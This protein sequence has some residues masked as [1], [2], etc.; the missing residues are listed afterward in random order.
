M[1][2]YSVKASSLK[3]IAVMALCAAAIV[4]CVLLIPDNAV[5]SYTVGAVERQRGDFKNVKSNDD[6]VE[7]LESY[8]WEIDPNAVEITEVT[9]PSEFNEVY[10]EYNSIQETEGLNLEKYSGKS[11]KRYTYTV[12]NYGAETTVLATLLIYKNRVIGGDISSADPN[13]FSHG[14]TKTVSE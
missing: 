8:G 4:S 6:R 13:G 14:F 1:F 11:V 3:Y 9:I 2:I 12:K 10:S 7:F 5:D